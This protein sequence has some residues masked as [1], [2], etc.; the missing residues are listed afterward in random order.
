MMVMP[1]TPWYYLSG[2]TIGIGY[3]FSLAFAVIKV[4]AYLRFR[5]PSLLWF[6]IGGF[7]SL[8]LLPLNAG[9]TLF[10]KSMMQSAAAAGGRGGGL[11]VMRVLEMHQAVSLVTILISYALTLVFLILLLRDLRRLLDHQRPPAGIPPSAT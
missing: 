1:G 8:L 9:T 4:V 5:L 6:M 11:R 10:T 2:A 7:W 3:G